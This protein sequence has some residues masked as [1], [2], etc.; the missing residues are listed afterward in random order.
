MRC[1]KTN[2]NEDCISLESIPGGKDPILGGAR[3]PGS[4]TLRCLGK[5]VERSCMRR[6][7]GGQVTE[8]KRDVL[9]EIKEEHRERLTIDL[10]IKMHIILTIISIYTFFPP[11]IPTAL[12]KTPFPP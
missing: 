4:E 6:R 10:C 5:D 11:L 12:L 2:F 3:T 1:E 7:E 8:L 9:H